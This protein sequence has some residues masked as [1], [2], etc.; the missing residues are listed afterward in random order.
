MLNSVNPAVRFW[1]VKNI[2]VEKLAASSTAFSRTAVS[3]SSIVIR[4]CDA[5]VPE[6]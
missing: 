4:I 6:D 2:V 1:G 5:M 3:R